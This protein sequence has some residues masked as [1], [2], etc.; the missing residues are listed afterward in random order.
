AMPWRGT[1]SGHM[2]INNDT[3]RPIVELAI[4]SRR[5]VLP[6]DVRSRAG[7]GLAEVAAPGRAT[8][9]R[10]GHSHGPAGLA[11]RHAARRAPRRTDMGGPYATCAPDRPR[12]VRSGRRRHDP[13]P[14]LHQEGSQD[15]EAGS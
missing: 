2:H 9:D 3:F 13:S 4:D 8:T 12:A 7:T 10:R 5:A 6:R 11:H 1:S 14:W 15:A